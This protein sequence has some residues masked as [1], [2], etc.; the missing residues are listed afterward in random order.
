[1][2]DKLGSYFSS[3]SSFL[4][5]VGLYF[6]VSPSQQRVRTIRFVTFVY[7]AIVMDLYIKNL[8]RTKQFQ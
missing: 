2:H 3:P 5:W 4:A 8:F 7:F 6:L 1:M